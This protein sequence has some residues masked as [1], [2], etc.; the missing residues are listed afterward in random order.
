MC[1][2]TEEGYLPEMKFRQTV[3][4]ALLNNAAAGAG[5]TGTLCLRMRDALETGCFPRR[6][7]LF[8]LMIAKPLLGF[9]LRL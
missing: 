8:Y 7:E 1:R 5:R 2:V 4:K 9:Y 6:A 3:G